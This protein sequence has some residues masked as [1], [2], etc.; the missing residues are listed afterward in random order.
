MRAL[1]WERRCDYNR[2]ETPA[3]GGT[4][5]ITGAEPDIAAALAASLIRRGAHT[6]VVQSLSGRA[7]LSILTEGL[8]DLPPAARHFSVLQAALSVS[9]VQARIVVLDRN[10]NPDPMRLGGCEGL[11]RTLRLERPGTP[12]Q[13]MTLAVSCGVDEAAQR[14]AGA[15]GCAEDVMLA[16]DGIHAASLGAALTPPTSRSADAS[17]GIWLVTGGGRGVTSDCTV[18]V[19]RRTG[20]HFVLFGRSQQVPW[21]EWLGVSDD[22]KS[23]RAELARN[24][25]RPDVPKRPAD[26]GQL[27]QRLVASRE[28]VG[29]LARIRAAGA[30]ATYV[31]ADLSDLNRLRAVLNEVVSHGTRVTGLIHGAGVLADGHVEKQTAGT[32]RKVFAPKVDGLIALLGALDL[33][34]LRYAGLFSSASAVFG[35]PG[36]ANYAAA[37]GW[38]NALAGQLAEVY[39]QI[40]VRSFCWGPWEGGMVDDTLARMFEARGIPLIARPEGARIFADQLLDAT[41][42]NVHLVVGEEWNAG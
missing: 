36:Q 11:V 12:I 2:Q 3:G 17:G 38:L 4:I 22:L 32:F 6:E 25:G 1:V 28:I 8:S 23:V 14:I 16:N 34:E 19:A 20:G 18:E 26:I 41:H 30:E 39:P 29:T 35:N 33:S 10:A 9:D 15:L 24:S 27:A 21:P 40:R 13:T 7:P 42:G 31:S 5:E 37:N